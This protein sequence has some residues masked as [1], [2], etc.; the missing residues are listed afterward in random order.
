ASS[1]GT[2]H[3]IR[4]PTVA[5][6]MGN[7]TTRNLEPKCCVNSTALALSVPSFFMRS[8]YE[9]PR[10][11][12]DGGALT[13]RTR[14][15]QRNCGGGDVPGNQPTGSPSVTNVKQRPSGRTK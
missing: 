3:V 4:T 11:P 8:V 2:R 12:V 5:Q 14:S 10:R 15:T 13:T 1:L 7:E 9:T 6:P